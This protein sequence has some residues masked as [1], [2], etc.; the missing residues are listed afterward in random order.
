[1]FDSHVGVKQGEPLSPLLFVLFINDLAD[2]LKGS[3]NNDEL[4]TMDHIQ[5]FLLLFADDTLLLSETKEGLQSLLDKLHIYCIKWNVTVNT[6]KSKVMVFKNGTRLENI[7]FYYN[8]IKLEMVKKFTYLGVT[9]SSNGKFYQSQKHLAEQASKALFALN[10]LFESTSLDIQDKVKLFDSMILPILMYSSEIWGFHDSTD[11][12]RVHV[13]FLKQLLCVRSQTCNHAVYGEFGRVPLV[14]KRKE[15]ILK[16]WMKIILNHNTLLYNVYK[17]ELETLEADNNCA[18]YSWVKQVKDL[19][20]E[21]GFTYLWNSQYVTNLQLQMVI[22]RLYDQY[23]QS[24][25]SYVNESSKLSTYKS[26]KTQFQYEKYLSC[27]QIEKHRVALTRL[28]CSAH[29][30]MIEEGRY[31]SIDRDLRLC[32]F[33]NM[34]SVETEYHF[35]L[36]CPAYREIRYSCL[37]AYYCRWPSL[38]KFLQLMTNSRNSL[39]QKLAKY[40]YLATKHRKSFL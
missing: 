13:K 35:L 18:A 27:V 22:Q 5:L 16:Y 12:E 24:W 39:L 30:L 1:M 31:R 10:N 20:C 3:S 14:V 2:F 19:L 25:Y 38:T 11:I 40:V 26:V 21:L 34:N 29:N 4:L 8:N 7:D 32:Q 23:I 36:V 6:D 17:L 28:R 9:L 15:R 33:C 37:P